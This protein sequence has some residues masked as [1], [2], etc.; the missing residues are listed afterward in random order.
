MST[1]FVIDVVSTGEHFELETNALMAAG[2]FT[3]EFVD[4]LNRQSGAGT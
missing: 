1:Q 4:A 2:G 3:G